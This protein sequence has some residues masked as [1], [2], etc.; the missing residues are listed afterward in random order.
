MTIRRFAHHCRVHL[1]VVLSPIHVRNCASPGLHGWHPTHMPVDSFLRRLQCV[2]VDNATRG[3]DSFFKVDDPV[4]VSSNVSPCCS[5]SAHPILLD[6]VARRIEFEA[7]RLLSS[8][9][10]YDAIDVEHA[11][12]LASSAL[13]LKLRRWSTCEPPPQQHSTP[14]P[15]IDLVLRT[16]L[17]VVQS[18][19]KGGHPGGRFSSLSRGFVRLGNGVRPEV[20]AQIDMG[21]NRVLEAGTLSLEDQPCPAGDDAPLLSVQ[22]IAEVIPVL[23]ISPV[24][25]SAMKMQ[26]SSLS[27]LLLC[28]LARWTVVVISHDGVDVGVDVASLLD[29]LYR[30]LRS[31]VE[32][33]ELRDISSVTDLLSIA[34]GVCALLPQGGSSSLKSSTASSGNERRAP[35]ATAYLSHFLERV[36]AQLAPFLPA[37]RP[38]QLVAALQCALV[39]GR[40][41][42]SSSSNNVAP[43]ILSLL[44]DQVAAAA[45]ADMMGAFS[46]L[47]PLFLLTA[48]SMEGATHMSRRI[49]GLVVRFPH[50]IA[51]HELRLWRVKSS[52]QRSNKLRS[53]SEAV[54]PLLSA[55][56]QHPHIQPTS[57]DDVVR[58]LVLAVRDV[59]ESDIEHLV[60][61]I[62]IF[63]AVVAPSTNRS[64]RLVEWLYPTIDTVGKRVT[65]G[66]HG[67]SVV[68]G[69]V[70]RGWFI[71][72][73]LHAV[74]MR[75]D[76]EVHKTLMRHIHAAT[77]IEA[78]SSNLFDSEL[79]QT[80]GIATRQ[81]LRT[82]R[83]GCPSSVTHAVAT[84]H[85]L[86]S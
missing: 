32:C 68:D 72:V 79:K 54:V 80:L 15:T 52:A 84:M 17:V 7:N 82:Q 59:S 42:R 81:F 83:Q 8:S 37:S 48:N 40:V 66:N 63:L 61:L 85:R 16:F 2:S 26:N 45:P 33:M 23:E 55:L 25:A 71:V 19:A 20:A 69:N 43:K 18:A 74:A 12:L 38:H 9:E 73:L 39:V 4:E 30:M 62:R 22:T 11:S 57:L 77:V 36:L 34:Q 13:R 44:E 50:V 28:F 5:T 31:V 27:I 76:D 65:F 29:Q 3:L 10:P 46:W 70:L 41:A 14:S 67:S 24:W 60:L 47:F 35:S 6:A 51:E 56:V 58:D 53:S 78:E 1:C 86:F 64:P 75:A 21:W 49:A